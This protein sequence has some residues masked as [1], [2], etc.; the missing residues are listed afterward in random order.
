MQ[1]ADNRLPSLQSECLKSRRKSFPKETS[2]ASSIIRKSMSGRAYCEIGARGEQGKATK[3][4]FESKSLIIGFLV[5]AQCLKS[6]RKSFA[7]ETSLASSIIRKNMS[8]RAYC[9]IG[10]RGEQ[11]KATKYRVESKSLIIG[12]LVSNQNVC[13]SAKVFPKGDKS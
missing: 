11:G 9:E 8:G 6:R 10:A 13:L 7:K 4:R 12:F 2:L 5:Q 3:Y 1:I